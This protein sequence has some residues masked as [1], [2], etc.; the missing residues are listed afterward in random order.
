MQNCNCLETNGISVDCEKND[1]G[2]L[3]GTLVQV[4]FDNV[5]GN[6]VFGYNKCFTAT[7]FC[8][9]CICTKKI[10]RTA[11]IELADKIRTKQ[12][13]IEQIE[14]IEKLLE[15]AEKTLPPKKTLGIVNYSVLNDLQFYHTIHNRSQ[16]TMHDVYEGAMPFIL[17]IFFQHLIENKIITEEEIEERIGSFGYGRLERKN[18]PSKLCLQKKNLNQNASQ[19]HC[20]MRHFPFIF[21]YLLQQ[22]DQSKRSI[23]HKAWPIIENILKIDQI[24]CS[25]VIKEENLINLEKFTHEFLTHIKEKCKKKIIPK[26]HFMVHYSNTI[27]T[28]GP[29][30][31]LQVMRGDAKHQQFTQYAKRCRN[32]MNITK[33][34]S[35]KHQEVLS[36]KWS[37]NTYCDSVKISKKKLKI[38]SKKGELIKE[39]ANHS[40][41]LYDYF[42]DINR[43]ML[44]NFIVLNSSTFA[45]GLFITFSNQMHQIEAILEHNDSFMF[46]CTSFATVKF[47]KFAK[48]FEIQ[49][50]KEMSI[51][52]FNM[53]ACKKTWEAK[54]LN[55]KPHIIADDVEMIP[56]YE[57][58]IV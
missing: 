49:S 44:V 39:V 53:L 56:I 48:C 10:S 23:V 26:L 41:L 12:Q 28:L 31:Y 13:Y 18:V 45:K 16:D 27:R 40:K 29:L 57:E 42:G 1:S 30:R 36:V 4:S 50:S 3:K 34:L 20:L 11:T 22:N 43:L 21:A 17:H 33:T 47:F 24:I 51:I 14:I 6:T 37:K 8:R 7:Y 46:L 35:E 9:I 25:R 52:N 32:Y 15:S 55:N 19:M 38:I 5:G 54:F 2:N 58:F